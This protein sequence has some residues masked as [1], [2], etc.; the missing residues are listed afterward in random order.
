MPDPI[1]S[2]YGLTRA[3]LITGFLISLV[4][5]AAYLVQPA[6]I[7]ST[8]NRTIDVVLNLAHTAP[9][10]GSI[11]IVD[12]DEKSLARYGQWPWPRNLLA[13]LLGTINQSAPASVALD[14][15]LA[16]PDRTSPL[17]VQAHRKGKPDHHREISGATGVLPDHDQDLADTLAKGPFVLGYQF[18][19]RNV[20]KPQTS[21]ELHPPSIVCINMPDA[22]EDHSLFF[23][24][25]GL[26]CNRQ[27]FSD[28]VTHSGFMNATP[29][30]DGILRRMPMLIRFEDRLYPSLALAAMMQYQKSSQIE[31]LLKKG[32]GS[33]DLMVGNRSVPVDFQGNMI[34]QFTRRYDATSRISAGDILDGKFSP[35][36]LKKK[37]VMVGSSAAGLEPTYQTSTRP[38]YTHSE[39]HA[40]VLDNLLTGQLAIRTRAFLIWEVMVG[41]L[42][43]TFSCLAI[44][45]MRILPSTAVCGTL[46]AGTWL[47]VRLVFQARGYLFSP[48][49][50]TTLIALNYA[51]L[52]IFKTWKIQVV[53]REV[54]DS[55]LMLLKSSEENLNAVIKA[56]P[57]VIFRLDAA[58]R[59]AFIS[60]AIA[61]YDASPDDL[62]G[63]SM[64]TLIKTEYRD[65]F[66]KLT[67]D[68]LQGVPGNLDLK[69]ETVSLKGREQWLETHV[70]P[71]RNEAGEIVS[72][73]GIARNITGRKHSE[74]I[75]AEKQ[76]QLEE[77]NESLEQR[78]MESVADS[79]KKDQIL[80][81][82]SR[83]AAM[84]EMI[85]NI[86]HQW[87]Q[88]LNTLGLI[89]QELRMT[90]GREEF[91]KESL[92]ASVS[93]AMGLISHMS[94]TIDNFSNY[95]KP[96]KEKALF[97][98]NQA[99]AD[100]ISLVELS[101]KNQG[102]KIEVVE[103]AD[104]RV[105]G[106][107]NEYS[108][109][110]LNILFNCKD[111]FEECHSDGER[112]VRITI[113]E[114]ND[115]S[116]VTVADN[117][118]GIPEE[119]MDKIFDPYFT[120]KE[121]GK[122]TGIGLYMSKAI[123]EKNMGGRLAM[124]NT[125]DGAEFRIEV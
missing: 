59:I 57:D 106:Y 66:V 52:T 107:V 53:V 109:V 49:F 93:K 108:Q 61:K 45:R 34:V 33:L 2:K 31:I 56:V 65:A 78:V 44:A 50:P 16:E 120:T 25:R 99:V 7:R 6:F 15:V 14:M 60:P 38:V 118:G 54:A 113:F 62:R 114:E 124:R 80:L 95:F 12:I 85:G 75:L 20:P 48:L 112:L 115:K 9:A 110:L 89:V 18:L 10:S 55:T 73:L 23:T 119:V 74:K 17:G 67:E 90:Y 84:G 69:F 26:V 43:A 36:R 91:N 87:R 116:V 51:V 100:T 46:L 121:Q 94:K 64:L 88:P 81:Q 97:N 76:S 35:E 125:A 77:M 41:L 3:L 71:F 117:A 98:V 39:I 30:E 123:I 58:G 86:A 24:A 4:M 92:E 13:Q 122:G 68:A 72:L 11:V 104:A 21:R 111:A 29:D 83:L 22:V 96:D 32:S 40:Q 19:F 28:A 105:N 37:V 102:I 1:H 70:V 47:G 63:Q 42:A 27:L 8:N 101:F 5:S 103:T 82:Q 79:R